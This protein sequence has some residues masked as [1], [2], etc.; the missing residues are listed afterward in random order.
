MHSAGELLAYIDALPDDLLP[1]AFGYLQA[2]ICR[3]QLQAVAPAAPPAPENL[4]STKRAAEYL[5]IAPD[6]LRDRARA[7]HVA[8][9]QDG[10][11]GRMHFDRADLDAYKLRIR[12]G[13]VGC[14]L[15]QWY[16]APDATR[17]GEAPSPPTR[18]NAAPARGRPRGDGN[19][20]RPLGARGARR[21]AARG[22]EP[23]APGQAAWAD[24]PP[25]PK[26]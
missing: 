23:A 17:R 21:V 11:G 20:R 5:D 2:R 7:G 1:A 10:D 19:D 22:D 26:G 16:S 4:W 25:R 9:H 24:T 12:K 3:R 14:D 8:Y 15:Y 6:E 18:L 13:S